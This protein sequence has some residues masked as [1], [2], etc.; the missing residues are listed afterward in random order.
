MDD[1]R[2]YGRMTPPRQRLALERLVTEGALSTEQADAV[3]SAL[4]PAAGPARL[5]TGAV[6]IEIAGYLGGGLILGGTLLYSALAP[7][8]LTKAA[9]VELLAGIA[10]A[11]IVVALGVAGGPRG[12]RTLRPRPEHQAKAVRG[13]LVAVLFALAA[14]PAT[15]G[16]GKAVEGHGALVGGLVGTVVAAGG[17]AA[18]RRAPGLLSLAWTSILA[19]IGGVQSTSDSSRLVI[20]LAL[21][22]LGVVWCV[23]TFA[24]MAGPRGLG[25]AIAAVIT[26]V[27]A[28]IPFE[29][30][31]ER[32]VAYTLMLL[33]ALAFFLLYWHD[34]SLVLLLAGVIAV[35]IVVFEALSRV[36]GNPLN[37]PVFLFVAGAVLVLAS[38]V[39]L[40]TRA[41]R[42][43]EQG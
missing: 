15:I 4:W 2:T 28:Q 30:E 1:E 6:L 40:R 25:W 24:G 8:V 36:L 32:I 17:Y 23:F 43:I 20:S 33:A 41:G 37:R 12:L 38:A 19:V 11:L 39:G 29:I 18:V 5:S 42:R 34:Q 35:I 9:R 31:D 22:G 27:G 21:T 14:V 26:M 13:R 16:A 3:E 10:L 7:D